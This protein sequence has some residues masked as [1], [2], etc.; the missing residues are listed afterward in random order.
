MSPIEDFLATRH[1][2]VESEWLRILNRELNP[3]AP[4]LNT[5]LLVQTYQYIVEHPR[6][7]SQ[8]HWGVHRFFGPNQ[9]CF[10][11]HAAQLAGAVP[12]LTLGSR[13]GRNIDVITP[14]GE[15][16]KVDRYAEDVLGLTRAQSN[17]LF[18]EFASLYLIRTSIRQWTG[19]DPSH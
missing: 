19:V 3:K 10:A 17:I 6:E 15:T 5:R 2:D 7:Y 14:A 11:G 16:V 12:K 18:S 8:K 13:F 9:F 1:I 4:N